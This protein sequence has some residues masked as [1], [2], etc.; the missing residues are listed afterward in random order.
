MRCH[1][2][3]RHPRMV[4]LLTIQDVT[5]R[6]NPWEN[7]VMDTSLNIGHTVSVAIAY[8]DQHGNPM[9]VEPKPDTAPVPA[10]TNTTSATET[11]AVSADGL[12]CVGTPIAVGTDVIS[13]ALSVGGVMYSATLGVTVTAEPQVFTSIGLVPTVSA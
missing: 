11:I 10:W 4:V 2:L 12:S 7:L 1:W 5:I 6:L 9:L 8:F 13:L 3:H